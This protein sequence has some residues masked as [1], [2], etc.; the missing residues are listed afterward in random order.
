ME[1]WERDQI[2]DVAQAMPDVDDRDIPLIIERA[3]ELQDREEASRRDHSS[4]EEVHGIA[5]ELGIEASFV[6]QAL[7]EHRNPA[8]GPGVGIPGR[9]VK[10]SPKAHET[11]ASQTQ[12][13][14]MR[15]AELWMVGS[16]VSVFFCAGFLA[17]WPAYLFMRARLSI[18]EGKLADGQ[19]RITQAKRLWIVMVGV[20]A[21]L[22]AGAIVL[23]LVLK[24]GA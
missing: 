16:L 9:P 17:L 7:Q 6:E 18:R 14:L 19:A 20:M 10:P 8:L 23:L 13:E 5:Q 24:V 15:Q 3:Q 2:R 21:V 4:P 22:Y 11:E 1:R 12:A